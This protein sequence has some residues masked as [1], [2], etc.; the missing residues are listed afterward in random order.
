MGLGK[1]IQISSFINGLFE[2]KLGKLVIVASPVTVLQTWIKELRKWTPNCK[3]IITFH[4]AKEFERKQILR[5]VAKSSGNTVLVTSYGMINTHVALFAKEFK[6]II[7]DVLI[8]DEGHKIKNV[9]THISKNLRMLKCN[10]KFALTGTP[11]MNRI[12]EMWGKYV[13]IFN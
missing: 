4:K 2:S 6:D 5:S 13:D 8:L 12:N 9:K 11:I 3:N 1:T 7:V 10:S